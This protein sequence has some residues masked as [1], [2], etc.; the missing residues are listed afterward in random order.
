MVRAEFMGRVRVVLLD[1]G[2][3]YRSSP[4][5][6]SDPEY[7]VRR[8]LKFWRMKLKSALKTCSIERTSA[9]GNSRGPDHTLSTI[10]ESF[11]VSR[12]RQ[13]RSDTP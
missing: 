3:E 4:G 12:P 2:S 6:P 11:L 13:L 1:K 9:T 5:V 7:Q 10:S 8:T